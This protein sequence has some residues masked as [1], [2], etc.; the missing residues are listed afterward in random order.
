MHTSRPR[1]II[2]AKAWDL[3]RSLLETEKTFQR[4][5]NA[6]ERIA[7]QSKHMRT[8]ENSTTTCGCDVTED[9]PSNAPGPIDPKTGQHTC[10]Y[11]LKPEEIAKGFVRPVRRTYTH[12]YM[13]DGS[14]VPSVITSADVENM[15]GCGVA[16]TMS[17]PIAET[18]AREPGYYGATFCVGCGKHLPVGE[19]GEFVWDDGT[20]VGT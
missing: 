7:R 12:M 18:Y 19:Y 17:Q 9:S 1:N 6:S 3:Y 11:V 20:K 4:L 13:K 2:G 5:R 16:T 8:P 14:P 15:G 10:Y